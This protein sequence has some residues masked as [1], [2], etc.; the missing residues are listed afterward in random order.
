[1]TMQAQ[2]NAIHEQTLAKLPTE[3]VQFDES[4]QA[5]V[6]SGLDQNCLKVGEVAPEF[7]LPD[8]KGKMV[9]LAYLLKQGPLI[10][11]FYRGGWC[12]YCNL[13]LKAL[14]IA[15]PWFED[16]DANLVAISPQL[17]D[18]SLSTVE[19]DGLSYP[20][21]SDVGNVIARKYG[22]VFAVEEALRPIYLRL[23]LDL[24][25]SNGDDSFELPMP[26]TFILDQQGVIRGAFVNAD[27][28]QRMEPTD[29]VMVLK[30]IKGVE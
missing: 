25:A 13:E 19:K 30:Q 8:V 28:K 7:V 15:M 4:T 17:P 27:Y 20:V 6:Q 24:P 23:G 1:M 26:G 18:A 16:Y 2:L 22:L 29:I 5:L 3:A 10:L 11:N 14:Q 12:P 21:L 9:E